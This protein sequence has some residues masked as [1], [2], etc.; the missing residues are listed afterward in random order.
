MFS[1]MSNEEGCH[2]RVTERHYQQASFSGVGARGV[3]NASKAVP[4]HNDHDSSCAI[5][6]D[7]NDYTGEAL[8][9]TD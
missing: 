1:D 3:S 5:M 7:M 6:F 8:L 9:P 4:S 2:V